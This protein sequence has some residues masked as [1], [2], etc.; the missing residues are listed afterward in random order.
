MTPLRQKMIRELELQRRS[1]KTIDAYVTAVAQ[2]A[3]FYHRSPEKISVEG[4]RSFVHHL[5]VDRKLAFSS[6]NQKVAGIRFFYRHVL[7]QEDFQLKVPMKRS[8]RLP[9]PLSRTEVSRLINAARNPKHRAKLMAACRTAKAALTIGD[10]T[11]TGW[12]SATTGCFAVKT[13]KCDSATRIIPTISK[14]SSCPSRRLLPT[15]FGLHP[16][17]SVGGLSCFRRFLQHVL[18]SRFQ[19]IRHYGFLANRF[20]FQRL[21]QCR[22]LLGLRSAELRQQK[23]RAAERMRVLLDIDITRCPCCGDTLR[24][25]Q[26]PSV[27]PASIG[28][29]GLRAAKQRKPWGTS[30]SGNGHDQHRTILPDA[31]RRL[32]RQTRSRRGPAAT[33]DETR[34]GLF[35]PQKTPSPHPTCQPAGFDGKRP[36]RRLAQSIL[37]YRNLP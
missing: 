12:R 13:V 29:C 33:S 31:C 2:L 35:S 18:P 6:C 3:A 20:K 36:H 15:A 5:I 28:P 27:A 9:E 22:R 14:A 16:S 8:G 1:P 34:R 25:E 24:R 21:A 10:A 11:R 37:P 32:Q 7:G 23:P 17:S 19:W 4:I 26:L 30:S